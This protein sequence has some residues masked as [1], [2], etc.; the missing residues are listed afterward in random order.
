MGVSRNLGTTAKVQIQ[1]ELMRVLKGQRTM[2]G[3]GSFT[4]HEMEMCMGIPKKSM[5]PTQMP[6]N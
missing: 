2:L 1:V 6:F 3:V 5:A 4:D